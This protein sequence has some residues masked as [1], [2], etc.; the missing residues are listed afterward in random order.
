VII[1]V[2]L[3][4]R[5]VSAARDADV[6]HSSSGFSKWQHQSDGSRYRWA[7]GRATFFVSPAA[8]SIRI[9]LRRAPAA[10]AAIEVTIYLDG[11]E[12]NRVILRADDGE[13][14]VRLNLLRPAKTRFA[15][16]DLESRVPGESRALDIQ[17]TETG[18][19]L[20]VGR[21]IPES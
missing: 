1:A 6:E 9:P 8:R 7:G 20:M 3:P 14:T 12:A 5:I 13:K 19:V 21:P 18:G 2:T 17:A 16:V 11:I 10:P 4:A 15:R